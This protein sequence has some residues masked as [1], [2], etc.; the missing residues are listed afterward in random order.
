MLEGPHLLHAQQHRGRSRLT[1]PWC[2]LGG[3]SPLCARASSGQIRAAQF[4]QRRVRILR[5]KRARQALAR[6]QQE[7]DALVGSMVTGQFK[8]GSVALDF[9]AGLTHGALGTLHPPPSLPWRA[10][11][12]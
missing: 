8:G 11:T 6:A 7:R 3:H 10:K 4:L 9:I 1:R 5:A 12:L 2:V